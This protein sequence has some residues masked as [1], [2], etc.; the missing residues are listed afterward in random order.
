MTVTGNVVIFPVGTRVDVTKVG[1]V[2]SD[3]VT[4][5]ELALAVLVAYSLSWGL[6]D[7]SAS[8]QIC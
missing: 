4:F 8:R 3:V 5:T 2:K 7:A 1:D 6:E